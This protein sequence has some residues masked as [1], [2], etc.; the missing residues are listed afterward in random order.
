MAKITPE[1]IIPES[2]NG[3]KAKLENIY[4]G[5]D[6]NW[7]LDSNAPDGQFVIA[8]S[9]L[10][11]QL[12][13]EQVKTYN[14]RDPNQAEDQALADI[15][16]HQNI[17]FEKQRQSTISLQLNGDDG[18]EVLALTQIKNLSNDSIW[19][20]QHD[21]VIPGRGDYVSEE[22]G[23]ISSDGDW[24][25][26]NPTLGFD[27]VS[28]PL[29][30]IIGRN[31]ET[32]EEFRARRK[33]VVARPSVGVLDGISSELYSVED[34]LDVSMLE[35]DT[36]EVVDGLPPNSIRPIVLGGI[37]DDVFNA[38]FIK[39]GVGYQHVGNFEKTFP[40]GS[41][42]KIIRFDRPDNIP[43]FVKISVF[44]GTYLTNEM[45]DAVKNSIVKYSQGFLNQNALY[46]FN[47]YGF[48][49]GQD[50]SSGSLYTPVNATLG[51][52]FSSDD[53][54]YVNEI[55]ISSNGTDFYNV[56]SVN[57]N[58]IAEF[59]VENIEFVNI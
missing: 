7:I 43:I 23:L 36:H 30:F 18:S 49:I 41:G 55:T 37:D 29:D 58:S 35:N 24:E 50:P 13:Q 9:Q 34:V 4:R 12:D 45:K 3:Y 46:N 19:V 57:S 8:V 38:I 14:Y 27:S 26:Q 59:S 40:V 42:T 28:D 39:R 31:D 10:L 53:R 51:A 33:N 15:G 22:Y 17:Q 6:P 25:L 54:V 11:Y 16:S 5:I 20:L 44:G 32:N 2:L 56:I 52:M 21:V 1:G 47:F 48:K